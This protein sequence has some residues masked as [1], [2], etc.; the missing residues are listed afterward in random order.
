M[1]KKVI[2]IRICYEVPFSITSILIYYR[3]KSDIRVKCYCCLNLL[4]ASVLNYERLNIIRDSIGHP[5]KKLF[6]LEFAQSFSF[7]LRA[8]RYITGF[9]RTSKLK[10]IAVCIG[11][12]FPF[13]IMRVSIYY[14]TQSD[15]RVK[16]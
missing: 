7:E 9:S 15:I 5:S 12:E 11:Y 6:S 2:V 13:S 3:T 16:C 8:S 10:V 1:K 4:R 14:R